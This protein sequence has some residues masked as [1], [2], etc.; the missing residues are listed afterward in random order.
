VLDPQPSQRVTSLTPDG[1]PARV[2]NLDRSPGRWGNPLSRV[3]GRAAPWEN[4]QIMVVEGQEGMDIRTRGTQYQTVLCVKI[5]RTASLCVE[6]CH[7]F[8]LYTHFLLSSKRPNTRSNHDMALSYL[9]FSYLIFSQ[10]KDTPSRRGKQIVL[11]YRKRT[12]Y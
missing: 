8:H 12:I 1:V 10:L 5:C 7:D 4:P 3:L 11:E 2:D 6:R 9:I